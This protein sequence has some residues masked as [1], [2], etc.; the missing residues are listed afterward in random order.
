MQ[1][2]AGFCGDYPATDNGTAWGSYHLDLD[3]YWGYSLENCALPV[4]PASP[5]SH[6]G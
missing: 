6:S 3:Y 5:T 4:V 2:A 1:S